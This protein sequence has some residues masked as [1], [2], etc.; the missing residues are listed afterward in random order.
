MPPN[1]QERL[2]D[3]RLQ[4]QACIRC[5]YASTR[6]IPL[7]GSGEYRSP[8]LIV[9]PSPNKRDDE[10]GEV[11]SGRGVAK[12]E[13]MLKSAELDIKQVYRTHLIRCF[14]GREPQFGEFSAFKRCQSYTVQMLKI[15]RPRA[16]V[17]CGLK[18]FK[19]MIIKWTR[20][21]VDEHTF[22][23]WIGRSVRLK[24]VWGELKFFIIE[25]PAVLAKARNR[26]AELKSI[27]L[28]ANMRNYVRAQQSGE[29]IALDMTDLKRRGTKRPDQQ[30][31][32]WS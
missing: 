24:E 3:L 25:S 20:E 7:I 13:K 27:E 17:I 11:F 15:M 32:G 21:R 10:E 19:W 26:E 22:Y 30:T 16:V 18:A 14:S 9:G 2:R 31:F 23:R 29:P 5:P 28:L 1:K 12:L 8:I 4:I 6:Q